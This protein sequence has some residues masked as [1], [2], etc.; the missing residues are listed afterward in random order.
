ML[1]ASIVAELDGDRRDAQRAMNPAARGVNATARRRV[2]N[3]LLVRQAALD[4]RE[5]VMCKP[6]RTGRRVFGLRVV[7]VVI[8]RVVIEKNKRS[9]TIGFQS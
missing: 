3:Q 4:G 6:R 1:T 8:G 9:R 2:A 5:P 7:E